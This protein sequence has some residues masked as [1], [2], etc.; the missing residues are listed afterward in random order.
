MPECY[1]SLQLLFA[2]IIQKII[3]FHTDID[4]GEKSKYWF[5]VPHSPLHIAKFII[6]TLYIF[7][8]ACTQKHAILITGYDVTLH[9]KYT[10]TYNQ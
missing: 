6:Y 3:Q 8:I 9:D 2:I 10:N 1:L 7:K 5:N 4:G